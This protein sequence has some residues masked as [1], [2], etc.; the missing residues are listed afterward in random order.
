MVEA[1]IIIGTG[2]IILNL[3]PIILKKYKYL[4]LTG[5]ISLFLVLLLVFKII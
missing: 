5:V 2:I 1:N 4:I 3:I